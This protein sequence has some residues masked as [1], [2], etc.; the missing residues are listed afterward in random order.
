MIPTNGF[1][2]FFDSLAMKTPLRRRALVLGDFDA[3]APA[4]AAG[5]DHTAQDTPPPAQCFLKTLAD[6]VH[7]MTWRAGI[8]NFEQGFADLKALPEAQPLQ[9][10]ATSRDVFLG[11]SRRDAE[12]LERLGIYKQ[13]LPAAAAP[14]MNAVLESLVLNGKNLVVLTHRLAMRRQ[15]E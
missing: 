15:L 13:D 5:L 10:D 8:R 1:R 2:L 3:V 14:A 4:D 6:F 7:L 12:F 11:A 9:R